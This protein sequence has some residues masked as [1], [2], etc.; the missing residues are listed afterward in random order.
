MAHPPLGILRAVVDPRVQISDPRVEAYILDAV[1]VGG[2]AGLSA[3]ARAVMRELE[4][5]SVRESFPIVGPVAGRTLCLLAGLSGAQRIFC[6]GSGTGYAA[7]WLAAGAGP[8]AQIHCVDWSPESAERVRDAMSRAGF[9]VDLDIRTGDP[10]ALLERESGHLDL[11]YNDVDK[12]LYP[13]AARAAFAR[14]RPGGVYI[15]DRALW[16]GKVCVGGTTW[17]GWTTAIANHN[18][19][20]FAHPDLFTTILDQGDGLLVAVKRGS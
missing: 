7:L 11:V 19:E 9:Q 1:D 16:Y 14:L 18:R 8:G 10:V 13:R 2:G 4:E 12:G 3:A 5:A 15:A 6:A 20:V 17:D